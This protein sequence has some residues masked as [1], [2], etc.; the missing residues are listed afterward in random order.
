MKNRLFFTFLSCLGSILADEAPPQTS[1]KTPPPPCPFQ[2]CTP[3]IPKSREVMV[4]LFGECLFLQPN[5][6]SLYYAVEAF[7]LDT[8][9]DIPAVSPHWQVFEV[10]PNYSPAFNVGARVHFSDMD[11]SISANWERLFSSKKTSH[12]TQGVDEQMIGPIFDIGPGAHNFPEAKTTARFHFDQA[13][14]NF[15]QR[16]SAFSR[17]YPNFSAGGT[18]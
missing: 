4:E 14:L 9:L 16:F 8:S 18:F 1:S 11:T 5:G 15:G 10:T 7:P 12:T 3:F 13:N 17:F 2:S 6:S